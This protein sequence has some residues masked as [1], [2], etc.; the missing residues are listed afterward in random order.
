VAIRTLILGVDVDGIEDFDL[1]GGDDDDQDDD[2]LADL[3]DEMVS[4]VVL[5]Q[6][7]SV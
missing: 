4:E 5:Y 7:N 2:D 6:Q 1:S 3:I